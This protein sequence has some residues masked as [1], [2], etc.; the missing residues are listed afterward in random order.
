MAH[1][2]YYEQ[3]VPVTIL[4]NFEG[5]DYTFETTAAVVP[6]SKLPNKFE[7]IFL[8]QIGFLNRMIH[9][10]IPS[11]VMTMQGKEV[12]KD[13]WGLLCIDMFVDVVGEEAVVF[14]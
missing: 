2:L 8:G 13:Q 3:I 4:I 12:L 5:L 6:S 14:D 9:T 7:G 11:L 1:E 10:F